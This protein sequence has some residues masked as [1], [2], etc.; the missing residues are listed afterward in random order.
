MP[1]AGTPAALLEF[2]LWGAFGL[3]FAL[4]FGWERRWRKRWARGQ[5]LRMGC[6][7]SV[8]AL[9]A[10][11]LVPATLTAIVPSRYHGVTLAV[12]LLLSMAAWLFFGYVLVTAAFRQDED[13]S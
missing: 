8:A 4:S 12:S 9:V 2:C 7:G 3:A 1:G 5:R 6:I 13:G 11:P 10:V